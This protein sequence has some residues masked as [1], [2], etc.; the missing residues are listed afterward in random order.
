MEQPA[1]LPLRVRSFRSRRVIPA[2][3][4]RVKVTLPDRVGDPGVVV[5]DTTDVGAAGPTYT[6]NRATWAGVAGDAEGAL[7]GVEP[8]I[9]RNSMT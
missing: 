1:A 8:R 7:Y 5:K 9:P 3:N 2:P 6:P 4:L